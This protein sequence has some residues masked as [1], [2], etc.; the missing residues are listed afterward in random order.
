MPRK[1]RPNPPPEEIRPAE[2]G[3]VILSPQDLSNR[4]QVPL[5]TIYKWNAEG[6]GP[7]YFRVGR[8]VRYELTEVRRW[9]RSNAVDHRR[10]S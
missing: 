3:D 9:E 8:H 6:T 2:A 4:Y 1:T 7:A 5:Q 10:A